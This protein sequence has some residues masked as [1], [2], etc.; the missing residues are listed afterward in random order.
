MADRNY[1]PSSPSSENDADETESPEDEAEPEPTLPNETIEIKSKKLTR[2][3]LSQ[4]DTWK[5]NM[6][7]IKRNLG[8]EYIN[9]AKKKIE[10]RKMKEPCK[11]KCRLKCF[12]KFTENQ[13]RSIF[14]T[15]WQLG[16]L[17]KQRHFIDKHISNISPQ[18]RNTKPGSNRSKNLKYTF[19]IGD[20]LIQI[21]KTFFKNTLDINNR[22]I[23][24]VTKK[25]NEHG[26]L[27]GEKRGR[28]GKQK[29][30]KTDVI[31]GIK[32]HIDSFPKKMSHYCREKTKKE[33]LDGSLN[34]ATMY[35][36]YVQ[37]CIANNKECAK[38]SMYKKIFNTEYNIAFHVPKNDQCSLCANYENGSEE[39]KKKI[40]DKYEKHLQEKE[41]SRQEKKIDSQR[42]DN[43][44]V[45]CFDLQAVL[46]T[47]NGEISSFY[48]KRRLA[49][50]NFTIYN[51]KEKLG[52]CFLWHEGIAKRGANEIGS[53]LYKYL[54]SEEC[55]SGDIIFYSDNC[56]G[57]NKNKFIFTLYLFCVQN[58]EKIKTIT[59]KFLIKGHTQNEGDSMHATIERE[60]NRMLKSGPIYTPAH[61]ASIIR[62]AK[63]SGAPY[64]LTEMDTTDIFDVKALCTQMG[65]NFVKNTNNEKIVWNDVKIVRVEK[66]KPNIIFYKTSYGQA[67]FKSIDVRPNAKRLRNQEQKTLFELAPA[68]R[69]APRIDA[70]KKKDLLDLCKENA[71]ISVYWPFYQSLSDNS[72]DGEKKTDSEISNSSDSE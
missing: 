70:K 57:Q 58:I 11:E 49:T 14:E 66:T 30:V 27:E 42:T 39:D 9:A 48:Y 60:K 12:S 61:W 52:S 50:Y 67:D 29:R 28:H 8:E 10:K 71:I 62:L 33:Y 69:Q 38:F 37:I 16:S 59:H 26:F 55:K 5:K 40:R 51:I 72:K 45:C 47:P 17:D 54:L 22:T 1:D 44:L 65:K 7:K 6:K 35:R 13:R 43:V 19:E 4:P 23:F 25:K 20:Q 32:R 41:L 64:K 56:A 21:C 36:L 53:C 46:T 3:R 31:N 24:T 2:K 18:Y 15:Y 68:Y 34:I 63:K